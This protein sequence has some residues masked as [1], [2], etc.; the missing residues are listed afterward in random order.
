MEHRTARVPNLPSLRAVIIH[1][2]ALGLCLV[3]SKNGFAFDYPLQ[4]EEVREAYYLGQKLGREELAE[5]LG[6]YNHEFKYPSGNPA[7]YVQS[8][9]FQTPYEHIVLR[10]LRTVQYSKFQADEDYRANPSLVIVR[11]VVALRFNYA[12]PVPPADRFRV[13]VSQTTPLEP[14]SITTSVLCDP[15]N[16]YAVNNGCGPFSREFVLR[17]DAKQFAHGRATVRVLLPDG[18]SQET[19]YNLDRIK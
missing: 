12:G 5:F 7:A 14:K 2:L 16:V 4:P 9:E 11:V 15:T 17:F 1:I 10:T 18:Q 19:K 3:L 6:Q 13:I 8:V